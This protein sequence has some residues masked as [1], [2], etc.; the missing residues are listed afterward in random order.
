MG[1]EA[2]SEEFRSAFPIVD[3]AFPHPQQRGQLLFPH[4]DGYDAARKAFNTMI[5]KRPAAILRCAGASD[6]IKGVD[7]ARDH[8]LIVSVLGGGHNV[9]GHS[10]C[11]G[12]LMID[13]SSMKGLRVDPTRR[14]AQAQPGLKLG[15]FDRET[16]SF[17]LATPMGIVADTGIAGLTLGGGIGWLNGKYG[18]ACDNLVSA[19]VVT[20]DGRFLTA[21]ATEN[22]DLFWALRGGGGNFGIVVSFE[23]QL[24][25]IGQVIGGAVLHPLEKAKEVLRFYREFTSSCPDELSTMTALL[26][27]PDGTPVAAIA[28]YYCGSLKE[29]EKVLQPLR[30]FGSPLL[31]FIGPKSHVEVQSMFDAWFPPGRQHYWKSNFI[32]EVSDTVIETFVDHMARKPS[33]STLAY[34]EHVHGAASRVPVTDTAFP[35]RLEHHDFAIISQ[36]DEPA[37]A[38]QNVSWTRGFWEAMQADAEEAVYVN[39]LGEEG[40]ERV[41]AAYGPN[42][43]R[44]AALKKKYDP[45]NFFRLNQNIPPG[46]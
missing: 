14:R 10:V 37:D 21:S 35:H 7:L 8:G 6:V 2:F 41:R 42:Y 1:T 13:L 33:G 28:V 17:G 32:G 15:E 27:A 45:T 44:L 46:P 34:L 43:D 25:P 22:A 20:A 18:L 24:H 4:D 31:D 36:W 40:E 3:S 26:P 23:Y 12:G 30:S 38:E 39:N 16:Q 29:G 9:A 5:D 19:D 11:D